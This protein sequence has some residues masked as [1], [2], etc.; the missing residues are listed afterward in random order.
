[1]STTPEQAWEVYAKADCLYSAQQVERAL[2]RLAEQ[3]TERLRG[4]NPLL[5]CV[6]NGAVVTA[7]QLLTRLDFPLEL[8]YL[9]ATRYQGETRGGELHWI[10]HPRTSVAGRTLLVVDD[11]FDEG[12]TLAAIVAALRAE[13]AGEVLSA[14]LVEKRHDR[15]PEG[16][17]PEFIGLEV[18]DRY[19]FGYGMDYKEY[20]RNVPGI[21]AVPD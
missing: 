1:M 14:V 20:L 13:G 11:I 6:L 15:K 19:V 21:F 7:G 2:D 3:L 18:E 9:H 4:T 17:R 12:I 16:F 5:L 10:A 8:D